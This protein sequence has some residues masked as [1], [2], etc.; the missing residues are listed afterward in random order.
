MIRALAKLFRGL[1][2]SIGITD[3]PPG[4]TPAQEKNF[5]LMWLAII[6]AVIGWGAIV[7]YFV[8]FLV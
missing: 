3:L 4:A 6:I 8:L 1:H 5:V 2:R 7:L